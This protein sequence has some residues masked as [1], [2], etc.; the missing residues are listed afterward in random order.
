[1]KTTKTYKLDNFILN[2]LND[3]AKDSN[4]NNTEI[5][6]RAIDMAYSI[7]YFY[8]KYK[9]EKKEENPILNREQELNIICLITEKW[10][11]K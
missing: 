2:K 9:E 1:M 11:W 5:I 3:M 7:S 4:M 8:N 6:E 10:R